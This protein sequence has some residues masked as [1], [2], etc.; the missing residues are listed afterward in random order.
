MHGASLLRPIYCGV[1]NLAQDSCADLTILG[2][3]FDLIQK[4]QYYPTHGIKAD[5][6][7]K[8]LNQHMQALAKYRMLFRLVL[9]LS[10]QVRLD[11]V[12]STLQCMTISIMP[13]APDRIALSAAHQSVQIPECQ[14]GFCFRSCELRL[15]FSGLEFPVQP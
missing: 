13:P 7:S 11:T 14:R 15:R 12:P 10:A 2:L 3:R 4:G 8:L 5:G 9:M 6:F 1:G